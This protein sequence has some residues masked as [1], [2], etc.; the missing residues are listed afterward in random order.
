MT[1]GYDRDNP[2][3]DCPFNIC[4]RG[5][6]YRPQITESIII[7][8]LFGA[9]CIERTGQATHFFVKC[10]E[11]PTLRLPTPGLHK[12][13]CGGP[14]SPPHYP[15]STSTPFSGPNPSFKCPQTVP[16]SL[17]KKCSKR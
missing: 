10:R 15:V 5:G 2:S 14:F 7:S 4:P 17:S 9:E 16:A 12:V 13:S 3:G 8:T 6:D 11:T 1:E